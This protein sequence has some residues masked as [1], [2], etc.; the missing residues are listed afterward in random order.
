MTTE[1]FIL[2]AKK[3]HGDKYDYSQ[4]NYVKTTI[5]VTIICPIHGPFTQ[6]P[7][8]HLRGKGCK[9]C[10]N[11]VKHTTEEFI[12]AARKVHGDKYDYSQVEYVNNKT[13]VKIIC[14]IHGLFE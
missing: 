1:E 8:N 14:P 4:V 10:G 2:K 12:E 11:A 9:Y 7:V 13:K 5:P 3:V 6:R